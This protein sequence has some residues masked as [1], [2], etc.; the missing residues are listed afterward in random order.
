MPFLAGALSARRYM[1]TDT[2]PTDIQQTATLALRRYSFR[3]IDDARGEKES[4][5]WVNPRHVLDDTFSFED[6][7]VTPYMYL[8]IRRDRKSFSPVLF[9]ARR[10]LRYGVVKKEKKI[11]KLS[12]QHRMALDEELTIEMLKE[13]SP[14][15]TFSELVWDMN[16]NVVYMGAT[17]NALCERIQEMFEATFDLK[18]RPLFPALIGADFILRQGLEEEYHLAGAMVEQAAAEED[19]V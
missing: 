10:E 19:D 18:L 12:R 7:F 6:V 3:P 2:V 1:V 8:G 9:R 11:E 4:T 17:S 13:T 16:T 15:S 5:G 14:A